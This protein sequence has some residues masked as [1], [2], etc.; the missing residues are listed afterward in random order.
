[1]DVRHLLPGIRAAVEDDAI[2]GAVDA[3]GHR[4]LVR[5]TGHLIKQAAGLGA[6]P[7]DGREVNVMFFRYDQYMRGRLRV[8]IAERDSP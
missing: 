7:G 8:D 6:G 5:K 1:M 3:L 2:A 4:D